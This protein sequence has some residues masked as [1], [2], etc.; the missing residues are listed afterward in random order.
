[1][2]DIQ[3]HGPGEGRPKN[4]TQTISLFV[5]GLLFIVGL[6]GILFPGFAGLHIGAAYSTL[7]A[8]SGA[9]LFWS[10]YRNNSQYA[11]VCCLAC[12]LFFGLH[13]IAGWTLGVPG[14]PRVGYDRPDPNWLSIIPNFHELGR[15]DHIMNTIIGLVLLGGTIDWWRRNTEKGHRT[16]KLRE[17]KKEIIHRP[18]SN[19][20]VHQ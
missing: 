11:F 17:I 6:C 19:R 12:T 13:A 2:T 14:T 16:E 7:I 9:L 8:I 10:G 1:M 3:T 15:N 5:G 20:P 18:N 4:S